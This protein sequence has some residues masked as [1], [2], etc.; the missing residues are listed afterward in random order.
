M[1]SFSGITTVPATQLGDLDDN[2]EVGVD[3]LLEI[4][5]N[6]GTPHEVEDLLQALS[7]WGECT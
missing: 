7:A 4:I 6:W 2:G 3:D 1:A 5:A